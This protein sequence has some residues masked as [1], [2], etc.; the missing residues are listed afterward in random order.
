MEPV[1]FILFNNILV[2]ISMK[3]FIY[4]SLF[5]L[6]LASSCI[7]VSSVSEDGLSA[8]LELCFS[9]PEMY[10]TTKGLADPWDEDLSDWLVWYRLTDGREIYFLKRMIFYS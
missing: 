8:D 10:V 6:T 7:K 4:I 9:V 5:V 1:G 2:V 3:K